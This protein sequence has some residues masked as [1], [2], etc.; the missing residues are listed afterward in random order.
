[1]RINKGNSL[2][3]T[4]RLNRIG[5]K[6]R[7]FRNENITRAE[8]SK[9][10][11]LTL[12]TITTNIHEMIL[13][14]MLEEIP[15]EGKNSG[16]V[17]RK[18]TFIRFRKDYACVVGVE[19]GPYSTRVVIV[20]AVG[21]LIRHKTIERAEKD[22]QK[23]L[24][25]LSIQILDI[26]PE[27]QKILGVG[28]GLPGFIEADSGIIRTN[29][30]EDWTGKHLA[31]DLEKRLNLPVYIDNNVRLMAL[32]YDLAMKNST[33]DTFAYFYMSKGIACPLVIKNELLSG[34]TAGSG[35]IGENA[36]SLLQE[37][38]TKKKV[39]DDLG[40]E[41]A[42][43]ESCNRLIREKK[44]LLKE[45][46]REKELTSIEEVLS[47]QEEGIIEVDQIVNQ[48]IEYMG[49]ALSHVVNLINP[50]LVVIDSQIFMR[51]ENKKAFK[52]S[53]RKYFYSLNEDEVKMVFVPYEETRGAKGAAYYIIKKLLLEN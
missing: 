30:R 5:I 53:A 48:A 51:E 22:Y 32:G 28:V 50:G 36:V 26:I 19:L 7:I 31:E 29:F 39:L 12:P 21:N 2:A 24:E 13:E 49:L 42:I 27:K 46:K 47:L 23:M 3:E 35:E 40:S 25:R 14:G 8:I 33:Y 1:M 4:K 43:F 37:G 6:N 9:S 45:E 15:L 18:P 17:G 16:M 44:L 34:F 52:K 11:S 38:Q 10:L 20:D 41:K